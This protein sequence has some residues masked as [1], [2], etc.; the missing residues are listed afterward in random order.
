MR[1]R[2]MGRAGIDVSEVGFGAWA[3][4]GTWGEVT[5]SDA[6]ASLHEA[7][8]RG[9][10][11]FD[12]ADVYGDGR[13]ERLIA[14]LRKERSGADIF[15]ATKAGRRLDPHVASGYNIENIESFVDRSLSNLATDRLDLL[16]LHCPPTDVYYNPG[17]FEDLGGLVEKG[18][19]AKYGVSVERVEEALKAIEYPDVVSVQIIFNMFRHRPAERFLQAA[20]EAGVGVIVRV[21]LA[22]GLLTG[23]MSAAS[24]FAGDDHRTFNRQ[25]EAFDMG[26]TFSGVPFERGL[27][28]VDALRDLVPDGATM[29]QLAL[30]WV[31]MHDAVSTVIPGA[32]TPAQVADNTAA[33]DL[34]P[35]DAATMGRVAEI[36]NEFVRPSVHHRW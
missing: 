4:G 26:E 14:R 30:R 12:T 31:L 36:Y 19:I 10:T 35:L 29:A 5:E 9:V 17:F 2:H 6:M 18:K 20:A 32:K 1:S 8:D 28:A 15:V 25:G 24:T 34:A 11:F 3:I 22:S 33:S 27:E 13:S 21:P 7:V 23:K 16:Q